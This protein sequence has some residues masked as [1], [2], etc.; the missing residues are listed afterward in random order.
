MTQIVEQPANETVNDEAVVEF[1]P[2]LHF[3][4]DYEI[5]NQFPFTIRKKSNHRVLSES[6][7]CGYVQVHLNR[8]PYRKHRLIGLQFLDNPDPVNF[9]VIDH[10]NRDRT[11]NHLSNLRW[12]SSS[13]NSYNKSS[14]MGVK[15]Q[16]VDDLPDDSTIIDFYIMKNDERKEFE[17][18]KYYYYHDESN[19]EDKFFG[20][21][22][23]DLY[24]V[25]HINTSK[26]GNEFISLRDVNNKKV[27]MMINRFKHQYDLL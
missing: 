22:T 9:D 21:I 23:D 13:S 8:K 20:K 24:K 5:L 15:Y 25:L 14:H 19:N 3:E 11:D 10:L 2:L 18:G 12:T 7:S 17:E 16:F 4:E 1:V 26:S 6:L 27:Y